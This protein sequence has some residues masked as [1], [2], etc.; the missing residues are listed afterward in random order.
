MKLKGILLTTATVPILVI[1]IVL[2]SYVSFRS[3]NALKHENEVA[4]HATV[5]ALRDDF[6]AVGD[7]NYFIGDDGCLYNGEDWNLSVDGIPILDEIKES[8]GIVTTIFYEN[9]RYVTSVVKADGQRAVGTTASDAVYQ[10]VV[11]EGQ[12][13]FA[14]N[15]D[16][17]GTP[18]FAYYIPMYSDIDGQEVPVGMVFAG[19]PMKELNSEI[20]AIVQ[21]IIVAAVIMVV[22]ALAVVT[23]VAT[24]LSNRFKAGVQVLEKVANGD[25]T[26][27][28]DSTLLKKKDET[29]DIARSVKNLRDKLSEV[30]SG[31]IHKSNEVDECASA[32]GS[33]SE[34]CATTIEQVEHAI[35]EIAD[36]ATS[37]AGDTTQATE[38]VIVM[39]EIVEQTNE[40]LNK[41]N[42]VSNEM[43]ESGRSA[44][45][46]L[47]KLESVNEKA[48]ESIEVIYNQTN[49]TNE[50]AKKISEAVNLITSIAE[51]TNLLSLNASIEAARAG[52][53]GKGFAVVA[54]QISKLAEQSNES[55]KQI[56]EIITTLMEDSEKAVTTMDEVREIMN[57]QS[58]MVA[59]SGEVF[60]Q[61]LA[62]ID[63]SRNGIKEI[64]D[65]MQE[66]N[67]SRQTVTDIVSNLSAI[68]EENA[69]STEETSAS[70]TEVATSVQEISQNASH[71]REISSELKDAI[72]IFKI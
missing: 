3:S 32:L 68:A 52:E 15:V 6:S 2:A 47:T 13:Y 19:K 29:G 24:R 26:V 48:K 62:N 1:C 66:L 30:L 69:A 60:K 58:D 4:L 16:V 39:G 28:V 50:S 23:W 9:T 12:E 41:L 11:K 43:E 31:I 27:E 63:V 14:S 51:E 18:H 71:L 38:K 61:V 67:K 7:N 33:S 55:A 65:N 36:G 40:S 42:N 49:T 59:E 54:G 44:S 45:G 34:E 64:S 53:M 72:S 5:V 22:I 46:T 35:L 25:L 70:T 10:K 21:G 17:A 20:G 8:S 37:Q 57:S 56:E